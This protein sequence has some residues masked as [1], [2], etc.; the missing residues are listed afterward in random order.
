MVR[1]FFACVL[2]SKIVDNKRKHEVG[3]VVAPEGGCVFYW[4]ISIYGQV[5]V[6][7]SVARLPS[8][9]SHGIPF[10]FSM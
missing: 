4:C 6:R 7:R 3:R 9:L 1:V 10:L 5:L 8:C 2:D